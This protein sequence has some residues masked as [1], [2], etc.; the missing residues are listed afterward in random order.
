M[1]EE[2]ELKDAALCILANKQEYVPSLTHSLSRSLA[3]CHA[4]ALSLA[5]ALALS[6]FLCYISSALVLHGFRV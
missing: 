3:R 4:L 6:R 1:L 2:E 5:L